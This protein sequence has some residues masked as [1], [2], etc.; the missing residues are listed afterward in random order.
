[1][2]ILH[3]IATGTPK[4]LNPD[5][6]PAVTLQCNTTAFGDHTMWPQTHQCRTQRGTMHHKAAQAK[7]IRILVTIIT[8]IRLFSF[9]T[10]Y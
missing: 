8:K 6:L 5:V 2:N 7:K 1:M 9:L 4:T 10:S 3:R